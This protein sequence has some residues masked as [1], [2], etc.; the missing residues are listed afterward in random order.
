[1]ICVGLL[2]FWL[3]GYIHFLFTGAIGVITWFLAIRV[4]RILS[5]GER[6]LLV[7][8]LPARLHRVAR[9]LIGT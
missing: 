9:L 6:S 7:T 5:P 4:V 3:D 2:L 8:V 1:G